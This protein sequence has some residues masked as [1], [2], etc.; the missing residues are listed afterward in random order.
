MKKGGILRLIIIF[1]VIEIILLA[2]S[3]FLN[4]QIQ[5]GFD[6]NGKFVFRNTPHEFV[7]SDRITEDF[8][9]DKF[10]EEQGEEKV[11]YGSEELY[12]S[13]TVLAKG[14]PVGTFQL[15]RMLLIVDIAL[16][17]FAFFT[18]KRL[19]ERPSKIQILFESIYGM[20]D[21][22]VVETL[23]AKLAGFTPYIVTIF[24]FLWICN[25]IGMIPIPGFLEP[26]RTLNVTM[27]MGI[28]VGV[29]VHATAI[30]HKGIGG[31][32][33]GYVTPMVILDV[34][35]ELAKVVSISFRLFG[36][37]L[38]GA[39]IILVVSSLVKFV[40]LPVGLNLFFG[41]FVGTVQAFVFT[42]LALSYISVAI[43]E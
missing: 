5:I 10:I 6:E 9:R 19:F 43:S 25:V 16:L 41:L 21:G 35:G 15:L 11:I 39:I 30:K 31:Y 33:K 23:G 40:V 27:G 34:I 2:L 13:M 3:G 28:M 37:I 12:N 1:A 17:F 8:Q 22:F 29:V 7:L 18:R 32:L 42:M 24:I 26:T 14:T 36:N 4:K 38:G 20:L